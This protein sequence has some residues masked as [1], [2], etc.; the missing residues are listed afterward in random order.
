MFL[1][2]RRRYFSVLV[3]IHCAPAGDFGPWSHLWAR[4]QGSPRF[5]HNRHIET[6]STRDPG[7]GRNLADAINSHHSGTSASR[8]SVKGGSPASCELTEG[9]GQLH[10]GVGKPRAAAVDRDRQSVRPSQSSPST[11]SQAVFFACSLSPFRSPSNP[12][13]LADANVEALGFRPNEVGI[14]RGSLRAPHCSAQPAQIAHPGI[15]LIKAPVGHDWPAFSRRYNGGK[16]AKGRQGI[17][18][19]SASLVPRS[20]AKLLHR[21]GLQSCAS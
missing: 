9:V 10:A 2:L 14:G 5:V 6:P 11:Q 17:D 21:R 7:L 13:F 1:P 8:A 4:R 15:V 19:L 20:L 3:G 18:A 16:R 12:V